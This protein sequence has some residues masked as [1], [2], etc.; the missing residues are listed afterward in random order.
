MG[1][2]RLPQSVYKFHAVLHVPLSLIVFRCIDSSPYYQGGTRYR[3]EFAVPIYQYGWKNSVW[4]VHLP[5]EKDIISTFKSSIDNIRA[6]DSTYSFSRIFHVTR[7]QQIR[8]QGELTGKKKGTSSTWCGM[9]RRSSM[10]CG[11]NLY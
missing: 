5:L 3:Q 1:W 8:V 10:L 6:Y 9:K 7:S 11:F 4:L 2:R